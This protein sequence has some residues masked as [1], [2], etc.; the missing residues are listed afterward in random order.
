MGQVT[1]QPMVGKSHDYIKQDEILDQLKHLQEDVEEMK[2]VLQ[3]S[4]NTLKQQLGHMLPKT[5]ES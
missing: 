5:I 4:C 1:K 3:S 2:V